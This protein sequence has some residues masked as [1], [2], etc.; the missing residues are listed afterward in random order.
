MTKVKLPGSILPLKR[1]WR[2]KTLSPAL[3]W[4]SRTPGMP[5]QHLKCAWSGRPE[6]LPSGTGET[7]RGVSRK[8][9]EGACLG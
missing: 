1:L 3:W 4:M 8:R 2:C 6:R 5:R 7:H 9:N